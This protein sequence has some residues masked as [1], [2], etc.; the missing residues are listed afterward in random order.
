MEQSA[1]EA[2]THSVCQEIPSQLWNPK[3]HYHFQKTPPLNPNQCQV[4][5]VHII[6]FHVS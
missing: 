1:S 3:V 5:P 2:E 4:N 6:T